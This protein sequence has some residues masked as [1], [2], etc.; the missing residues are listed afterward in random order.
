MLF[1]NSS[2]AQTEEDNAPSKVTIQGTQQLSLNSNITNKN[3]DLYV[4]LPSD[5]SDKSRVFPVVYLL[6]AQWDFTLMQSI[7]GQ[8]YF[9]GFIPQVVVVGITWGGKG[10]NYDSLRRQDFTPTR[11]VEYPDGG[12][13]A[14]F[15]QFIKKEL[16]P[17]VESKYRVKNDERTLIGTSLGGLFT[18]YTLLHETNLFNRYITTSPA[19]S[20]DNEITNKYEEEFASKNTKLPVKLY[21]GIGEY[22]NN[23]YLNKFLNLLKS[24]NYAGL[25]LKTR[26]LEEVG[27]SGTKPLGYTWGMQFA[28]NRPSIHV[29]LSVLKQYEGMYSAVP[30]KKLK[31][32]VENGNLM[33]LDDEG[34]SRLLLADSEHDFHAVGALIN[35]HFK[36]DSNGK[37]HGFQ[38]ERY[39]GTGFANPI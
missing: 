17:F 24:R 37:I 19:L 27:H 8:E 18:I 4:N 5:Y 25:E 2:R 10:A 33:L 36:P 26:E 23:S 7:Y 22:E 20:W 21:I 12:N 11:T 29:D 9:D 34:T 39:T 35:I 31:L 6:D 32:Y 14:N 28:F 38:I 13:A 16:I 1:S 30:G 15:L 3:Y